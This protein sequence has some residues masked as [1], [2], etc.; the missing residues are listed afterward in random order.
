[1]SHDPS[2]SFTAA[3]GTPYGAFLAD[4]RGTILGLD[5]R[6][7]SL[8]GWSAAEVVGRPRTFARRLDAAGEPLDEAWDA[9]FPE[10]EEGKG[11]VQ[12]TLRI[13]CRDGGAIDVEA[14]ASTTGGRADRFT[15]HV[16]RVLSR[17][18]VVAIDPAGL[19]VDPL[20]GLVSKDAFERRLAEIGPATVS[21]AR[22]LALVLV[23]VDQLRKVGDRFGRT[24]TERVL[25]RLAGI[26]RAEVREEDLVARL[27]EDD[28]AILLPG[29]GRGSARQFAARLRST[30]ERFRF[31]ETDAPAS[32]PLVTV[33]LGAASL[34]ADAENGA[35][36][37]ER[38]KE[39]LDEAR[40]LGR[41][42]VWCYTRRPRVPLRTPVYLD[43]AEPLLLGHSLDLSPS[44]LFVT[45]DSPIEVGMRCALS[46]PL[47]TSDGRVHVIGRV[48]RTVPFETDRAVPNLAVAGI[49]V[50]F[51]RF[52]P[53]DRRAIEAFLY[54]SE[55][56]SLR[57]ETGVL[58]LGS[59][60][61]VP[62][63]GASFPSRYTV[64]ENQT[65]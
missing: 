9:A 64:G 54:E 61:G 21:A 28:F 58:S 29:F 24:G 22:P 39:A 10:F 1:M 15:V 26:L 48:V 19:G 8:T 52:G 56:F 36:L 44:G 57:P 55:S 42:R 59:E 17:S 50:E 4:S 5:T 11:S 23:D 62:D 53:E 27:E 46:F 16:L 34:P 33:S 12:T 3:R 31:F 49:G 41:N 51:E 65:R 7:E 25:R 47:P 6:I 13:P 30:V 2:R 43:G 37:L 45:T 20:T 63:G 14:L 18:N 38:A 40:R 32:E 60:D 35:D